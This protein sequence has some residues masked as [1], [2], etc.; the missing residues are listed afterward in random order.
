ML[1]SCWLNAVLSSA[2]DAIMATWSWYAMERYSISLQ[3]S[4]L[5]TNNRLRRSTMDLAH[6]TKWQGT[7][8]VLLFLL[9]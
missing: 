4:Y 9:G 1:A 6:H 2:H 7:L 3:T 5:E 8:R